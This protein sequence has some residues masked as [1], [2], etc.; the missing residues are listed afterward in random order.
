[1]TTL[2]VIF[3]GAKNDGTVEVINISNVFPTLFQEGDEKIDA[4]DDDRR[5]CCAIVADR[6]HDFNIQPA[7]AN[8][9]IREVRGQSVVA[10]VA[11][12]LTAT[13]PP[14]APLALLPNADTGPM[15]TVFEA[16]GESTKIPPPLIAELRRR[17]MKES[18]IEH[19]DV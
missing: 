16:A 13:A 6:F 4:D 9:L 7:K 10:C 19:P 17:V 3:C 8:V 12:R 18:D 2:E 15:L 11:D 14:P 5:C 1:V